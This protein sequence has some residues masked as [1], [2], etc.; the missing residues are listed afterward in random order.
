MAVSAAQLWLDHLHQARWFQGKG[1][2]VHGLMIEPLPWYT[3]EDGVWVRSELATVQVADTPQTYHLLVGYLPAGAGEPEAL[4]GRT[5]VEG[6]PGPLDLVDAP[7][8]PRAMAALLKVLTGPGA[9][10]RPPRAP[11][12]TWHETPP[13]PDSPTVVFTGEQSNTTVQIGEDVLFKIFRKLTQGP[14]LESQVLAALAGSGITPRL[15]GDLT[16]PGGAEDLGLFI[17]RI[18]GATDGWEHCVAACRQGRSIAAEMTLL[19]STLRRLHASLAESF[20]TSET[21]S[22]RITRQMLAHLDVA[23]EQAPELAGLRPVLRT[24]FDLGQARVPVQRVHGD[25]H[26][27]QALV[28]PAGWTIIDFEGEPLKSPQ[29]RAAP[30]MV[31]R[32][33]A[34]LIR[35]L[36][37]ARS[38]HS[39]PDGESARDWY[40]SARS[41]FL[42]GYLGSSDL[43]RRLLTA[44]ELDKAVYELVYEVRNRPAW[45][46]IP[47]RAIRQA[48]ERSA[49]EPQ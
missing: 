3:R 26:L 24:M 7:R 13:D 43:P 37:Y 23:C 33:V 38:S 4:I 19:G 9:S 18:G 42:T 11:S 2:P 45:A 34:G 31:W 36:D 46:D 39:D 25:F 35:S 5:E 40:E 47:R 44:Y 20:P 28:S 10:G 30:D 49:G 32:D 27:G 29:E 21:S 22:E 41:A 15:I 6:R 17:E 48:I 1:L 8:S 14:N 16:A 12:V